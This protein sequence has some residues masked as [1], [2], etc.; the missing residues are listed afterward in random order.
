MEGYLTFRRPRRIITIVL[1]GFTVLILLL[2]FTFTRP[3]ARA[4]DSLD[5]SESKGSSNNGTGD[6]IAAKKARLHF[7]VPATSSNA[8]LCKLMLSAQIL[9]Y[10]TPVLINFGD[11]ENPDAYVQHLAKVQG[12]LDYLGSILERDKIAGVEEEHLVFIVDGYDVWLQL[13]RDVLVERYFASNA[14]ADERTAREFGQELFEQ[15]DMRQ[16]II[17]GPDKICWPIAIPDYALGPHQ[18]KGPL[19]LNTPRWL[20]SGTILGSARNLRDLFQATLDDIHRN[21]VTDSDQ[22]YVAEIFG[23]QEYARIERTRGLGPGK[24]LMVARKNWTYESGDFKG[25]GR[26]EPTI[27]GNRTEYHIGIDYTSSMFQTMAY[28]KQYLTL[29]RP[30]N[31]WPP[32]AHPDAYNPQ[33]V[34]VPDDVAQS[35]PPFSVLPDPSSGIDLDLAAKWDDVDLLYNV[36]TEQIP[37]LIH[38]A[39]L[40]GKEKAFREIWWHRMWFQERAETLRL[41]ALNVTARDAI[42]K[43]PSKKIGGYRWYNAEPPEADDI[44]LRG[45]DGAW[46]DAS[47]GWYSWRGLCSAFEPTIYNRT[48]N[49]YWHAWAPVTTTLNGT[50]NSTAISA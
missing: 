30:S 50:N 11:P 21:H 8:N 2:A 1:A 46:A 19:E 45:V 16:T 5:L 3:N 34:R 24:D 47:G 13:R 10:P 29:V 22:F 31:S 9:G 17:F 37:V 28:W 18:D 43:T 26:S 14:A 7:L 6:D 12:F 49:H 27:F 4:V 38:F 41:A 32:A 48:G 33:V 40:P 15:H 20:N 35:S 23:R 44:R 25:L 39:G 36:A 42:N